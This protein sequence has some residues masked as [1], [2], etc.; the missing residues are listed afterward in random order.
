MRTLG[1]VPLDP[2]FPDGPHDLDDTVADGLESLRQRI[3]QR[4]RFRRGSWEFDPDAGTESVIGH[5]TTAGIAGAVITAAIRDEGGDEIIE[6]T[7]VTVRLDAETRL[8]RYSA[9]VRSVHGDLAMSGSL[10]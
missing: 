2:D 3:D 1:T 6:V 10:V 8:F 9:Q 7:D 5:Q 4:L